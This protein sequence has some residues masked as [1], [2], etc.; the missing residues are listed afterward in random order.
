[1]E[2]FT[3]NKKNTKNTVLEE[4]KG[5]VSQN[6]RPSLKVVILMI[7]VAGIVY[8]LLLVMIGEITLP[9]Q[10]NGSLLTLNGKVVGSKLIA[11]EFKS[12]KFFHSRPSANSTSGVDPHISPDEAFSQ[13]TRISKATG[14]EE[15][16]LRTIVQL[17]LER[18][19]VSNVL[20]FAPQYMNVLQVNLDL[21]TAYPRIYQEFITNGQAR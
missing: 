9:F 10:S 15:N 13:I 20:V 5:I 17:D 11:Q 4:L 1:M 14:L 7:L 18:N 19:K 6:L 3:N 21:I 16:T 2:D 12:E 8:P